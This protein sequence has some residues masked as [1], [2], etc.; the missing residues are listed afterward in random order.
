MALVPAETT[1]LKGE[2]GLAGH[3]DDMDINEGDFG[4]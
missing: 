1:A 4:Q 3:G 2:G